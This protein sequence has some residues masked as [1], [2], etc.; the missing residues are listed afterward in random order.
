MVT[1]GER[2]AIA[3]DVEPSATPLVTP[4][5][6]E[7]A[8]PGDDEEDADGIILPPPRQNKCKSIGTFVIG[9]GLGSVLIIPHLFERR[10]TEFERM[11][12]TLGVFAGFIYIAGGCYGAVLGECRYLLP[13]LAAQIFMI[14]SMQVL[15]PDL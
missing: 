7:D 8:S 12:A 14:V 13:G 1:D 10:R 2:I 5:H 3:H 9:V 4:L 11:Q 6:V 15:F